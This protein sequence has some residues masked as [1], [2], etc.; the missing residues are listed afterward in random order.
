MLNY[1]LHEAQAGIKI[2]RGNI[3]NLRYADDTTPMAKS[4]EELKSLL[5]WVKEKSEKASLRLSFQKSKV[6]ASDPITSWQIDGQK[7]ETMTDFIFLHSK[8]TAEGDCSHGIKRHLLL[9]R[10]AMRNLNSILKST[11]TLLTMVHIVKALFFPVVM[12]GCESWTI[13]KAEH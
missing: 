5:M 10:K 1:V 11:D 13:N 6:I 4:E 2:A 7:V 12:Y 3:S 9:G 8:I